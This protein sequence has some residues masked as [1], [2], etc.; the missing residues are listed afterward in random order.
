M[1]CNFADATQ[2]KELI[3]ALKLDLESMPNAL[4]EVASKIAGTDTDGNPWTY[5]I[6]F[7]D[8]VG[9]LSLIESDNGIV[10]RMVLGESNAGSSF[11]HHHD[12]STQTILRT[13]HLL[14]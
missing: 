8:P 13:T 9:P 3:N 12:G 10:R 14:R 1:P 11:I 4:V 6:A 5:A 2:A 7:I